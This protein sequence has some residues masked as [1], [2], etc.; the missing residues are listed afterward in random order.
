[1]TEPELKLA[2][3]V[4]DLSASGVVRNAIRLA[5]HMAAGGQRTELWVVSNEGAFRDQVP[6][7][8]AIRAFGTGGKPGIRR[9]E[10]LKAARAIAG[11]ILAHRPQVLLSAGN[12]F[13]LA[14]GRAFR[15]AG[16][17]A[18]TRLMGRA[19]NATPRFGRALP[20]IAALANAVDARKY[21]ELQTV[22]A[23]SHEL[24]RD[25]ATRLQ[26]PEQRITVI[27]NGVDLDAVTRMA[28]EALDDPWF[29]VGS[30]PVIVSAGRL[31]KQ[32]NYPLLIDA[33]ARLRKG[34]QARLLILGEGSAGA[35][36]ALLG[37]SR[38]LGV[39]ADVRLHG[40]DP[41]PMRFFARAGLFVLSS[42]WEGASNVL[43]EAMACGCPVVAVDCPTG[44]REQ[45]D[46]GR[47]GPIVAM[48]DADALASAM[49]QRLDAPRASGDLKTHAGSFDHTLMLAAY[50]R[51]FSSAGGDGRTGGKASKDR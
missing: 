43:L 18:A 49:A 6:P 32:K 35:R 51:L 22:I 28:G 33:F 44:V 2:I 24:A 25:L 9:F 26:V 40:F 5:G 23:V 39:E 36:A 21:R 7:A 37:Q 1:M 19:S 12:H 13:H 8:V 29:A 3:L 42:R 15:L 11:A 45:L 38:S 10:T 34:R 27:P 50:E 31:S 14:A 4:H 48:N 17:P 41:N 47:V 30:P 46:G 16:R 20:G